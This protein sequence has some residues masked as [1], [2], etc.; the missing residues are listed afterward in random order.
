M[1]NLGIDPHLLQDPSS[2][3]RD[4]RRDVFASA[5]RH[6][7]ALYDAWERYR[8]IA[9]ELSSEPPRLVSR[10]FS[11]R[12]YELEEISRHIPWDDA[13]RLLHD[14]QDRCA[15]QGIDLMMEKWIDLY[16]AFTV[17]HV[18]HCGPSPQIARQG[19]LGS[20][21]AGGK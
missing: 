18:D 13:V 14:V 3:A 6:L 4:L 10:H 7:G 12:W 19:E 8:E 17:R 21:N 16:G 15:I 11:L 1:L 5:F 9:I 20:D 2:K